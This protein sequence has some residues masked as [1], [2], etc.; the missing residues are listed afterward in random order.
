[1]RYN[2]ERMSVRVAESD[3]LLRAEREKNVWT[4]DA[5]Q[6]FKDAFKSLATDELEAKAAQLKTT[7]KEELGGVVGPLKDELT[8]LDKHV[9]DLEAEREGA[10]SSI[11]TQLDGLHKLQDSLRQQTS[12]L[13]QALRAPTVRGRWRRDAPAPPSRARR[14]LEKHVD[15]SEQEGSQSRSSRHGS[16]G[17]PSGASCRWTP[18]CHSTLSQGDGSGYRG[19][20]QG[21]ARAARASLP[22]AHAGAVAAVPTGRSSRRCR[23]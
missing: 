16:C 8:K 11:G 10:Y 7:A 19:G 1:M 4:Q 17:C 18:R 14:G 3:A 23:K 22:R 20:A 2:L 6:Q 15:F 21:A 13:A 12:T 5:R 9:R